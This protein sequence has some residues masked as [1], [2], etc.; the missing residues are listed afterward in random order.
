MKKCSIYLDYVNSDN[1]D[2]NDKESMKDVIA[3]SLHCTDCSYDR[4][5]REEMLQK[6]ADFPEPEFPSNL[7]EILI[8]SA[9]DKEVEVDEKVDFITRFFTNLLRP[10]EIAIPLACI[11]MLCFMMS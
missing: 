3:H 10:M 5:I 7:H 6:L 4:K 8:S 2:E 11:I 9:F 1:Y